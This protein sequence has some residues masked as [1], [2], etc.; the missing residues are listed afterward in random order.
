MD[1]SLLAS[2]V[3]DS[4]RARR[5]SVSRATVP[6]DQSSPKTIEVKAPYTNPYPAL[7]NSFHRRHD[8]RRICF[9]SISE[10]QVRAKNGE[11]ASL[12]HPARRLDKQS[13]TCGNTEMRPRQLGEEFY[14]PDRALTSSRALP[15]DVQFSSRFRWISNANGHRVIDSKDGR[16]NRVLG[17]S[18]PV[19]SL[20]PFHAQTLLP[21]F[22]STRR[23][24]SVLLLWRRFME[25]SA[26]YY[27]RSVG[28]KV[29]VY[30][31]T[32]RDEPQSSPKSLKQTVQCGKWL[33]TRALEANLV[34]SCNS[35]DTSGFHAPGGLKIYIF[36]PNAL[37]S[38]NK[39]LASFA[40]SPFQ[41]PEN[42]LEAG[43]KTANIQ[44]KPVRFW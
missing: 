8:R 29:D 35:D 28:F 15:V 40:A 39:V 31:K 27:I 33:S 24:G 26:R 5:F 25:Y 18:E 6:P 41:G 21:P 2:Q 38:I 10:A 23:E 12:S 44:G 36:L 30:D 22:F 4:E 13:R 17:P 9:A 42:P 11:P 43:A 20:R 34:C 7:K 14:F 3:Q 32:E 1:S 16:N 37:Q 19:A